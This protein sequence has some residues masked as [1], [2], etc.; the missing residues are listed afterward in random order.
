M[1]YG[2]YDFSKNGKPTIVGR[3]QDLSRRIG[4]RRGVSVQDVKE[5]RKYYGC[6][7]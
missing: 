3:Y 1:H 6:R 4:Q 7:P 5:I 2:A